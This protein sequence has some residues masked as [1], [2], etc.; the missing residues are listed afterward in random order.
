MVTRPV[1]T[2]RFA[3]AR[4]VG[5]DGTEFE[6]QTTITPEGLVTV[7]SPSMAG[8]VIAEFGPG[9]VGRAGPRG[10]SVATPEGP[11]VVDK[12]PGGCGS[13]GGRR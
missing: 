1:G 2:V 4:V 6:G 5:P 10:W 12:I 9:L 7:L 8:E 13:C 3:Q 11:V